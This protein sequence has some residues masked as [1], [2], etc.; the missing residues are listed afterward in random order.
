[1]S[2]GLDQ[3]ITDLEAGFVDLVNGLRAAVQVL[4]D[5]NAVLRAQ[6]DELRRLYGNIR[7]DAPDVAVA[8]VPA[9]AV[10]PASQEHEGIEK[11]CVV[12]QKSFIQRSN[13]Q[14]RC[15]TCR[16]VAP[17]HRPVAVLAGTAAPDSTCERCGKPFVRSEGSA[18]RFCSRDC[19]AVLSVEGRRERIVAALQAGPS[20]PSALAKLD[21]LGDRVSR[22]TISNDLQSLC[23]QGRVKAT[24]R[25]WELVTTGAVASPPAVAA[26]EPDLPPLR[27][28]LL[29]VFPERRCARCLHKFKPT[30]EREYICPGCVGQPRV[31]PADPDPPL[32]T[33]WAPGRTARSLSGDGLWSSLGGAPDPKVGR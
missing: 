2:D 13:R 29:M 8:V 26:Q 6:R 19:Y 27:A 18:G 28:K 32:E 1:M 20:S 16:D 4:R 33:H 15:L 14:V 3:T 23:R 17:Q 9:V 31:K 30:A 25:G 10:A 11:N 22:V 5:E 21:T 24:D 7:L 12:C